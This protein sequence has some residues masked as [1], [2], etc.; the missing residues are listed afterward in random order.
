[1]STCG[2][3]GAST[4]QF[5]DLSPSSDES[6]SA[7][8]HGSTNLSDVE[9]EIPQ[10]DQT[11]AIQDAAPRDPE[12]PTVRIPSIAGPPLVV[13]RTIPQEI[14]PAV[15]GPGGTEPQKFHPGDMGT[16]VRI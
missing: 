14:V 1:M 10:K 13:E 12:I 9:P 11:V 7:S 6:S 15:P 8:N 4:R 3:A 5:E 16:N 2:G